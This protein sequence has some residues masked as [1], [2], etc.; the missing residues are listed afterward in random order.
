VV[1]PSF[2]EAEITALLRTCNGQDFEARRDAAITRILTDTGV[3]VTG[4]ADLRFD[5]EDDQKS[6]VFL[7]MRSL[8]VTPKGCGPVVGSDRVHCPSGHA[9]GAVPKAAPSFLLALSYMGRPA[10]A[11]R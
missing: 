1:K 10:Q 7:Q 11:S 5:A 4:L 9:E 2:T 8:R 3:R 6:D